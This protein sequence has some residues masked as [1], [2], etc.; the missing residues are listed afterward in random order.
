VQRPQRAGGDQRRAED[1]GGAIGTKH[2]RGQ[3]AGRA[4]LQLNEDLFAARKFLTPP[5]RQV[6]SVQRVPTIVDRDDFK[7]LQTMG[8]M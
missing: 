2:P 8:I 5:N 1:K 3:C 4:A 7:L 6:L